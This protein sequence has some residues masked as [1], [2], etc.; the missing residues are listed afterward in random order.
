MKRYTDLQTALLRSGE[1]QRTIPFY[2]DQPLDE[3]DNVEPIYSKP[4]K[5][6]RHSAG[7]GVVPLPREQFT[8]A[9][10][11]DLDESSR[12]GRRCC[13]R[14]RRCC[15]ASRGCC[16]TNCHR[17]RR[18]RRARRCSGCCCCGKPVRST[19]VCV[20]IGLILLAIVIVSL[21]IFFAVYFVVTAPASTATSTSS[22]PV[23]G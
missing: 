21:A 11:S 12:G 23:N 3:D 2:R 19:C 10:G 16:R 5:A 9:L 18:D 4:N 15:S 14:R 7:T 17:C 20:L 6:A 13:G 1:H 22:A 8:V